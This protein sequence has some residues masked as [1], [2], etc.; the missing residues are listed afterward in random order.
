MAKDLEDFYYI[1]DRKIDNYAA[2]VPSGLSR[3]LSAEIKANLGLISTKLTTQIPPQDRVTRMLLVRKFVE[4]RYKPGSTAEHTTW[5]KDR[6][7]VRHVQLRSNPSVLLLLGKNKEGD[8]CALVGSSTHL[9]GSRAA[10]SIDGTAS[11]FPAFARYVSRDI[12]KYD[13]RDAELDE[14]DPMWRFSGTVNPNEVASI[15]FCLQRDASGLEFNVSFLARRV[16]E[17]QNT[18][19]P[20]CRAFTPLYVTI[21]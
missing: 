9:V 4:D 18:G 8:I 15:L 11:Y 19:F 6:L 21:E 3:S 2:Q 14:A 1:S 20:T 17:Y 13:Y 7:N 16:F 12:E 10:E 5:V